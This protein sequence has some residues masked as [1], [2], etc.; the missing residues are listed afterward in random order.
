MGSIRILLVDDHRLAREGTRALLERAVDMNVVGE[1]AGA[2]EAV[3]LV[4][5]L[6]PKW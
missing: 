1:A 2:A 4:H 5:D 6:A 3:R